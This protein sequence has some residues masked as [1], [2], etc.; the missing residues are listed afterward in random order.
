MRPTIAWIT[1]AVKLTWVVVIVIKCQFC[2]EGGLST[3]TEMKCIKLQL[4]SIYQSPEDGSPMDDVVTLL[5]VKFV[6]GYTIILLIKNEGILP[7]SLP[8]QNMYA[9]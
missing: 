1:R 9:N 2:I 8:F 6:D 4:S 7:R 5:D 3:V